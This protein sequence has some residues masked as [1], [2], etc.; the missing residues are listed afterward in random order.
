MDK[1]GLAGQR[2]PEI[3][4]SLSLQLYIFNESTIYN[5]SGLPGL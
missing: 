3:Y 4:L 2:V 1:A 5:E